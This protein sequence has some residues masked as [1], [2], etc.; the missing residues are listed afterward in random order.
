MNI[1]ENTTGEQPEHEVFLCPN[2]GPFVRVFTEVWSRPADSPHAVELVQHVGQRAV[3]VDVL[4][5]RS[6]PEGEVVRYHYC[7]HC[8]ALIDRSVHLDWVS[9]FGRPPSRVRA[10][11]PPPVPPPEPSDEK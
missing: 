10:A 9:D 3:V 8:R 7:G 4:P 2:C 5:L 11:N 6:P 1:N